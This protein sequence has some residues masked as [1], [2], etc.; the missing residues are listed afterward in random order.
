ML[1]VSINTLRLWG[2]LERQAG[3]ILTYCVEKGYHVVKS[4]E[5][6]GSGMCEVKWTEKQRFGF[7]KLWL[8]ME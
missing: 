3:R 1:G 8:N 7:N 6:V 4:Y 5:E 2:D